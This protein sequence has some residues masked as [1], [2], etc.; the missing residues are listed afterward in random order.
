VPVG[1]QNITIKVNPVARDNYDSD[2]GKGS[3]IDV[4]GTGRLFHM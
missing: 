3:G 2:S 4:S 1:G